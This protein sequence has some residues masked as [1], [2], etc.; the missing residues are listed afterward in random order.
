MLPA[1][2]LVTRSPPMNRAGSGR[3][4][5]ARAAWSD[6]IVIAVLLVR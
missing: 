5:L 1:L 4:K 3:I 2:V 6:A